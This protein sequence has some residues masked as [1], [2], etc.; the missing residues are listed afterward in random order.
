MAAMCNDD[1]MLANHYINK[2][3]SHKIINIMTRPSSVEID[4]PQ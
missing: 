4:Y 1:N 3:R 2:L